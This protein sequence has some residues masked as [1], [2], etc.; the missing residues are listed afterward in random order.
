MQS[1]QSFNTNLNANKVNKLTRKRYE[2]VATCFDRKGKVLG[3]G[4][5]DYS[6]S[7]PLAKHFAIVAGESEQKDKVHA[8]LAAVL[9]SGRKNIY[10]IFVQRFHNDGTMAI[11]APCPTCKAMLKGF[12][13]KI[14]RYTTEEGIKEYEIL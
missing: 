6:R 5:N 3:T 14:V 10:S 7:H 4:V 1:F 12:G 2:I 13:V 11:A 8:E 9:A